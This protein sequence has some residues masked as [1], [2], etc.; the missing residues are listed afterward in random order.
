M[1][2]VSKI[3]NYMTSWINVMLLPMNRVNDIHIFKIQDSI[4]K[5]I[6]AKYCNEYAKQGITF[7]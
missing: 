5:H 7:S 4:P 3:S 1:L 2:D 6:K